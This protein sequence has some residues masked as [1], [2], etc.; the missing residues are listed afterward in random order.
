M[1][2]ISSSVKDRSSPSISV[3]TCHIW[4]CCVIFIMVRFH[5]TQWFL[6]EPLDF[7]VQMSSNEEALTVWLGKHWARERK[8]SQG[9]DFSPRRPSGG[10]ATPT[11]SPG[12]S[13]AV[14]RLLLFVLLT[15][16]AAP[17][18]L[19]TRV[20]RGRCPASSPTISP[21]PPSAVA[22]RLL[23]MT[24]CRTSWAFSMTSQGGRPG[25]AGG[26]WL[27][28]AWLWYLLIGVIFRS[29]E[30]K[31]GVVTHPCNLC[32]Q[33]AEAGGSPWVRNQPGLRSEF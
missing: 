1:E 2:R 13:W 6:K 16:K 15:L 26:S 24:H 29:R 30:M 3:L 19:C 23:G 22:T 20:W 9:L 5:P 11:G 8:T 18:R 31:L 25:R 7:H 14:T 21:E 27:P 33:E 4:I 32:T 28:F 17:Q 12:L 10:H